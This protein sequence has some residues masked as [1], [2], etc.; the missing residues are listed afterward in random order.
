MLPVNLVRFEIAS[1]ARGTTA[2]AQAGG[3][4]DVSRISSLTVVLEATAG[5][6]A[7][8]SAWLEGSIDGTNWFDLAADY[9]LKDT[10]VAGAGA[11][12]AQA[13]NIV[14]A[15]AAATFKYTAAYSNLAVKFVRLSYA[16]TTTHTW[17]AQL[18]G[19]AA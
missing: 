9:T 13:R 6:A 11:L 15:D 2:F 18:F 4:Y 17:Y 12:T 7:A 1:A 5:T 19:K 10:D 3:P 14:P 16:E 8:M